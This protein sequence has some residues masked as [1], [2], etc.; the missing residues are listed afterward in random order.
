MFYR[1]IIRSIKNDYKIYL[2]KKLNHVLYNKFLFFISLFFLS[3]RLERG[4][5]G[6]PSGRPLVGEAVREQT[7]GLAC[8]IWETGDPCTIRLG[9]PGVAKE[10]EGIAHSRGG[11]GR[12]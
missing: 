6:R 10:R 5:C 8:C 11:A 12:N 2:F 4:Q 1:T 3:A 7:T 9:R